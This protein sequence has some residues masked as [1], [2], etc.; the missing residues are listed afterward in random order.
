MRAIDA[1]AERVAHEARAAMRDAALH[2]RRAKARGAEEFAARY[3]DLATGLRDAARGFLP[4][5]N[6]RNGSR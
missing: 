2:W 6:Q 4:M 5:E 1:A 3:L